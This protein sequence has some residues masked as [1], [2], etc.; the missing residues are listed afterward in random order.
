MN[1]DKAG[2]PIPNVKFEIY[3]ANRELMDTISTDEEGIAV[4]KKMV[5][6][7]YI[8]KEVETGEAYLLDVKEYIVKLTKY[9]EMLEV[10]ITNEPKK[11]EKKLPRTG[12]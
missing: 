7:V 10:K 9:D 4:T 12:F 8:I 6:G 2:T 11:P 5:K 1:G 3:N